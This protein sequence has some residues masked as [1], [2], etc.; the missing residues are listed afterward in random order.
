MLDAMTATIIT[1]SMVDASSTSSATTM[2]LADKSGDKKSPLS[3]RTR[4]SSPDA[5]TASMPITRTTSA[6]LICAT[7]HANNNNLQAATT[8]QKNHSRSD[9]CTTRHARNDCWTSSKL[10][11]LAEPG[12]PSPLTKEQGRKQQQQ[13]IPCWV[14]FL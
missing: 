4:A 5:Y 2:V 12:T 3:A 10:S 14:K 9:T 7:K 6:M 13:K 1:I 8:T 11:C